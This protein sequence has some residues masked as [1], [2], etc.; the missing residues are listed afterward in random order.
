M[1]TNYNYFGGIVTN[2]L[3]LDLDAAKVAS[4]PGTGTAWY[5]I[6]GNNNN[7]TLTNGPT[8]SGIGKQAAIVFDGA[9]DYVFVSRSAMLEPTAITMQCVF[10]IN[11]MDSGN[12]PGIIAKGYWDSQTIPKDIEGYSIHIRPSTYNLWVDFNNNGTR[13][14]LQLGGD[15]INAGIT[16]NSLNFITVT[17]GPTG[18]NIYNKGV[19][20]YSDNNNYTIAYTGDNGGTVPADLWIGWMQYKGATLNGRVYNASVYNRALSATEVSQNFNALR[21]RYGI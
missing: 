18:A 20:Y 4:Y 21:G 13:K 7:G 1:A 10:Y 11:N 14:I 9:D 3:V 16:Q 2:G 5:D 12:Y 15:G 6:S 19:N 17:I 8:F